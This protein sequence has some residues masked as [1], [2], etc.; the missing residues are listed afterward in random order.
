MD[1]PSLK[2]VK[3]KVVPSTCGK[4]STRVAGDRS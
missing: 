3:I 1:K 2:A 4:C